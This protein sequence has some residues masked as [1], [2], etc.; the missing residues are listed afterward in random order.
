MY[1]FHTACNGKGFVLSTIVTG[2]NVHD[3]WMFKQL[4]K[5]VIKKVKRPKAV[6]IDAGYKILYTAN[7]LLNQE[8]RSV[9]VPYTGPLTK[10]RFLWK[11][12][13]VYNENYD[14]CI[15]LQGQALLSDN[16]T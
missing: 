6:A 10:E 7:Y 15:C 11:H 2:A 13:Y 12:E 4:L 5:Q 16:N 9:A 14:C 3:S 8:I 1:S